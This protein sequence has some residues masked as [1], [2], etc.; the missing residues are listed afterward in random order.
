[1]SSQKKYLTPTS[2]NSN[3]VRQSPDTADSA[4]ARLFRKQQIDQLIPVSQLYTR[5]FPSYSHTDS[6]IPR[7]HMYD[8]GSTLCM[9]PLDEKRNRPI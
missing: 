2:K 5:M 6:K 3:P 9:R 7:N 4:N 8:A 1:M